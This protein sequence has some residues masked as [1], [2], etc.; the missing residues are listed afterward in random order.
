[1]WHPSLNVSPIFLFIGG[2]ENCRLMCFCWVPAWFRLL[3]LVS[4]LSRLPK[5]MGKEESGKSD[6][7]EGD[8][9]HRCLFRE[10]STGSSLLSKVR[11]DLVS[12][13]QLCKGEAK[14]TNEV[15]LR[16]CYTVPP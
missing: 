9:L 1:M 16:W 13:E 8:A 11:G 10:V 5:S 2:R 14:A 15:G 7:D 3:W 6:S 12:V 4:W